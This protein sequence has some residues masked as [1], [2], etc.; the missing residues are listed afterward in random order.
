MSPDEPLPR[1]GHEE[2]DADPRMIGV[3]VAVILGLVL[4][5]LVVGRGIVRRDTSPQ[6]NASHASGFRDGPAE[7]LGIARDRNA[8]ARAVAAHLDRYGWIDRANGFVRVPLDRAID[9]TL[10]SGTSMAPATPPTQP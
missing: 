5:G 7:T 10:A 4:V 9:L 3:L 6:S 8:E 2:S 1:P